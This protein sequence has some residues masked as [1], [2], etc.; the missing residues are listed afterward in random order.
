MARLTATIEEGTPA[1]DLLEPAGSPWR[2]DQ[3]TRARTEG[4]IIS[5]YEHRFEH[6]TDRLARWIRDGDIAYRET[7]TEGIREAPNAFLGLFEGVN[8]GKQ[9]VRVA[10]PGE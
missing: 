2:L 4:F 9:L 7:V 6:I 1:A 3:P 10:D 8:I 5:D